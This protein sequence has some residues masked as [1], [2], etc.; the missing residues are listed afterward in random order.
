T[1]EAARSTLTTPGGSKMASRRR[2]RRAA[3]FAAARRASPAPNPV[4]KERAMSDK[5]DLKELKHTLATGTRVLHEE[6]IID[7]YGHLSYRL[8]GTDRFL[9]NPHQ[10]PALPRPETVITMTLDGTVVEGENRPNS[11][12]HIHASIYRV[13]PDVSSV[14]HAHNFM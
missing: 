2:R 5:S 12:W 8:P 13:R 11:E 1:A 6:G 3:P 10:S 4:S 7:A 14:C 9:I